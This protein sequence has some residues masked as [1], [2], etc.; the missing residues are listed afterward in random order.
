MAGCR[1]R[2]FLLDDHE[3]V[4]RGVRAMLSA[5]E[6]IEVV[7]EASSVA[8]A[9]MRIPLLTPDV[10]VLDVRL[11]DGSGIDV[12]REIRFAVP[13]VRCI[14][15]TSLD[16]ERSV[17]EAAMAG[18]SGYLLKQLRGTDLAGSVRSVAAG[19]SLLDPH[20]LTRF[21]EQFT[22]ARTGEAAIASL[23]RQESRVVRLIGEGFTNHEIARRMLLGEHTIKDHVSNVLAKLDMARPAHAAGAV[24]NPVASG[25]AAK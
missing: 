6:D 8:E 3:L 22:N 15:L 5:D 23:T 2:V 25:R 24:G 16:D 4:R 17:F 10:A 21:V 11:P 12:C 7:G 18:A 20:V 1:I 19:E 9:L 14:M 13:E